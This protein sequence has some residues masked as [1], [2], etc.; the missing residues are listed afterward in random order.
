MAFRHPKPAAAPPTRAS[1]RSVYVAT[2]RVAKFE[3]IERERNA[4]LMGGGPSKDTGE[5]LPGLPGLTRQTTPS[6]GIGTTAAVK[7]VAENA[8]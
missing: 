8:V 2:K 5:V 6:E 7:I 3:Q 4:V 1:T